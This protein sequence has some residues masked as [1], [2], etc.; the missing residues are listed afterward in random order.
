V[1][2][3]EPLLQLIGVCAEFDGVRRSVACIFHAT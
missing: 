3:H 2:G 1:C